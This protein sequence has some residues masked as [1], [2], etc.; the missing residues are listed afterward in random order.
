MQRF[1]AR[2]AKYAY[3]PRHAS[4]GTV[5]RG[6]TFTVECVEGWSSYFRSPTDFTPESHHAAEAVKWAVTGPIGV[7]GARAGGA[8]AITLQAVEI[9]TPGVAVYGPYAEGADPLSWWDNETGVE[10]YPLSDGEIRFDERTTLRARPIVGCLATV[11]GEGERHAMLQGTYGGNLDCK[12]LGVGATFVLPSAIDGAGLYLGDCKGL[13]SDGEIVAPPEVGALITA[14]AV[15][16]D[17]PAEMRWPRIETA[18]HITTVVSANPLERAA[19]EA[20]AELLAWITS[21]YDITRRQCA[22][23]MAM[24]AD[25]GICQVSNT[26]CTAYCTAPLDVLSRYAR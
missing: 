1:L 3:S 11:P 8:V 9:T 15:P 19:R 7:A 16:R 21:D 20:F 12:L 5:E 24:V 10:I 17:R 25:T 22:L 18:T 23:L 14:S 2:D 26:E 13:M 6:E 4:I